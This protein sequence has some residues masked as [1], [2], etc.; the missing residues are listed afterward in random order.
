MRISILASS[1][2]FIGA[3]WIC[4]TQIGLT[5]TARLQTDANAPYRAVMN[6]AV[7]GLRQMGY[8]IDPPAHLPQ[9]ITCD[10]CLAENHTF[11]A[12]EPDINK[13]I[14][15]SHLDLKSMEGRATLIHEYGHYLLTQAGIPV[16]QQELACLALGNGVY[17]KYFVAAANPQVTYP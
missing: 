14:V 3:C 5:E 12:Y 13:V 1:L 11:G 7:D 6:E 15:S 17:H 16:E 10:T 9:L 2:Y 4:G 8:H